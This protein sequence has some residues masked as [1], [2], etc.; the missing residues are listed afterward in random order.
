MDDKNIKE[1]IRISDKLDKS[2][3][4]GFEREKIKFLKVA[5]KLQ[6]WLLR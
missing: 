2:I 3:L 5:L 4:K 1:C 6:E